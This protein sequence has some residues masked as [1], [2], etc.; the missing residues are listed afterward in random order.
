MP[1]QYTTI[2]FTDADGNERERTVRLCSCCNE[3]PEVHVALEPIVLDGEVVLP[4]QYG[5]CASCYL[6]QRKR[7][8]PQEFAEPAP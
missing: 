4:H 6:E 5:V 7:K 1:F 2:K 3:R 8:Y